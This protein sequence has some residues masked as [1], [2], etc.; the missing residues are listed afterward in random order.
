[1]AP[2]I[3][4]NVRHLLELVAFRQRNVPRDRHVE[5]AIVHRCVASVPGE[6]DLD[7]EIVPLVRVAGKAAR[8]TGSGAKR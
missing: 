5:A 1:M 7:R 6:E 4:G 2:S 3:R 8:S